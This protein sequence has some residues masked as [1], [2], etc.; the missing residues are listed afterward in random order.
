MRLIS[1]LMALLYCVIFGAPSIYAQD[2]PTEKLY[3]TYNMWYENPRRMHCINYKVGTMI[4]AGSRIS[5]AKL[6]N[7][8]LDLSGPG[9]MAISGDT[10]FSFSLAGDDQKYIVYFEK[11]WHRGKNI[12]DYFSMMFT[13]QPLD[14]RM[15]GFSEEEKEAVRGGY[16]VKGMSREAVLIAYGY[17]PEHRT[18]NLE[19]NNWIYWRN[20]WGKKSIYFSSDG[21]TIKKEEIE[22]RL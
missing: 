11:K 17:P 2:I 10:F 4:P 19:L 21:R 8:A 16:L 12:E 18:P 7:E 5:S 6:I 15:S 9:Q 1:V 14:E 13:A 22:E 20:K 3:T